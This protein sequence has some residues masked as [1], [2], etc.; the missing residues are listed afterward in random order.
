MAILHLTTVIA[1]IAL[2][3]SSIVKSPSNDGTF[4][5]LILHNNDMHARFE[6]TS[7]LSGA[8][9]TADRDAGKCYG[10]FPRVAHV[11]KEA[12]KAAESGE[13]PPVLYLNAGDTYTGT[14]WFTI[15]KWKIAAEF[16]NALQPD[17]VSLGNNEF[18]TDKI[19][20]SP[21]MQSL[22][23]VVIATNVIVNTPEANEKIKKS[24]VLNINNVLVGIVGYLT[25][26]SSILDSAGN[27]EYIDEVLALT[28]EVNNLKKLNVDIII[29]LGQSSQKDLDV[30][31]EVQGV[32]IVIAGNQNIFY[33]NGTTLKSGKDDPQNIVIITQKSGKRVPVIKAYDYSKYLGKIATKFD[34]NGELINYDANYI[35]LDNSIPQDLEAERMVET[36]RTNLKSSSEIVG[37]TAVVLDAS[38]CKKEECNFGNLV[39]D[40][41]ILHYSVNYQ[42]DW[43]WTDAAIAIIHGGA[44][45]GKIAP[46]QRPGD[47][48]RNDLLSALPATNNLVV[49]N[50]TGKIIKEALEHS[51][52]SYTTSGSD[53]FLQLSGIRV[54]YN[55]DNEPGSRVVNVLVRCCRCTVPDF[56]AIQDTREHKI[57]MPSSLANGEF[58]YSMFKNLPKINLNYDE[59]HCVS[60]FLKLRNPVY[61]EIADRSLGNHEFDNG[62]NGLAPF[63][64]NLSCPNLATNLILDDEPIL[65]AEVNLKNSVVFDINGVKVAVIGYLT[66]DTKFLAIRN[67]VTYIDEVIAIK[68]EVKRL[69]KEGVNIFIALGHSGFVKDLEIAKEI[70]DIDLVIGG[71]TNTFLWNGPT[72]DIEKAQGPYPMIVKQESGR[73]V[74]VVQAYAYTKYIGY[75]HLTFDMQGEIKSIGET[76][77]ILLN[78]SIPEDLELLAIVNKYRD[79]ILKLTDVIVGSTSV[80]LDGQSCRLRECNLG[81]MI[82]DAIVQ[83]Y[84]SEYTGPGWTD[85]PIAITQGGGIRAS[86]SHVNKISDITWGDLLTVMPF[87]D[88]VVKVT[89]HGSDVRIM[90][91]HSVAAYNTIR[92]PGQFLQISGMQIEYDFSR[93]PGNRVSEALILCGECE[94]PLYLPLNDTRPYNILINGF[95][96]MGGDGY[97]IFIG[98]PISLGNHEFDQGVSGLTP[99]IENLKSPVLAANLILTKVP[100]LEKEVNLRNSI[101][102]NISGT[103]IGVI[104]YLTPETKHLVLPN[105]VE[106]IEEVTALQR[107]VKNLKE[108]GVKII[109]A[110]GH[111]GYL[112]DLEI[113]KKVDGL[114]LVIGGHTNT[115]LWN[116]TSPDTEKIIGPYPTYVTQTSGKQVPVVQ[117]YAYTKYLG[118]LHMVFN[119]EGELLR[120]DGNPI[121]LDNS[122]P[123]D[124]EVL[125]IINQYKEKVLNY[126]EEV[127]G[128]TSV[129]L[130]GLSCQHTECNLGN[131]IADAM[132]Y[133]YAMEY[134]GEHWTDAPIAVIQGG[135]IRSSISVTKIPTTITK[136]DL[137]AVLPFEGIL[138][139]VRMTGTILKKM[140]EHAISLGNHE[141]DEAVAGLVPF[142]KNLTSPVL[143][144][145][146]LLDNVPELKEETNLY[147]SIIL[148]KKGVNIGIVGYLTPETKFLAPKTKVDYEDEIT[149]VRREVKKLKQNGIDIII[150]L[151]HSGFIKDLEIATEVEDIDLVIGGHSNTFLSN[152]NTTE[153]PEFVQGPYPTIV[154]QKS[155]RKVLVVQAYAYT[156]YMGSL[157]LK[158]NEKG[159]IMDFD[160]KPILL[161]E[162]IPQ[163][164][165]VLQIVEKYHTD[166]DRINNEIVGAS[167]TFLQ[168]DTCRLFECNLG[169]FICDTMLNYTKRHYMEFSQVNIALI[170]GGRIRTSLDQPKKPY[171]LTRGD[172]IT[173]IP[174]SDTLC[175]VK[176]NGSVLMQAL[177][178]SVDLWR[179]IDTPG[180]FL[181]MSGMEV[182]YDLEKIPGHRVVSAKAMCIG[183][184]KLI[185]VRNDLKYNILMSAFL[186]DGGDGY[187]MFENLEKEFVSFNEVTC[188]L[189]YLGIYSPINPRVDKRITILNED[190]V[191]DFVNDVSIID[192]F[193]PSS[194]KAIYLDS[195]SIFML[196]VGVTIFLF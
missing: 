125:N 112:K 53:R 132:V 145:N 71:H 162:E 119:S 5:L 72:P 48:T 122:I 167:M 165:V 175:I 176:M 140:L 62:I 54:T 10:G 133:R 40:S 94:I 3:S 67:N 189:D 116:G 77:P 90:L 76:N 25:P 159:D 42:A 169:D 188:V 127:I 46:A 9:T 28:E 128:N 194:G 117:A 100:E 160:G 64:A 172:W 69:Q 70:E 99:F 146:L 104:G 34:R 29:A 68:A 88:K 184:S 186:A 91:E 52:S 81:N 126:T 178:H 65:K 63:I 102:F 21:L 15:Y 84:A 108:D 4:E 86:I 13:G 161:N 32:D 179:K 129:V 109:I 152:V 56:Y 157:F 16:L 155:G 177:E 7:Q 182:T 55:F 35:V 123:Q 114:S 154:M 115:F 187:S 134:N 120:A 39:T 131:L 95:L 24:V 111:S 149:S 80:F 45:N 47:I 43:R 20:L 101:V 17:A 6:Q 185:D 79:S 139:L 118:K 141:F 151:G 138:V 2:S 106:Y 49:V 44:L 124:P 136:G 89:L 105:D 192:K 59:V 196:F 11:V 163:D 85:T 38:S 148:N 195:L 153:I 74:P 58:G 92:A 73:K 97:S 51:V 110:L 18:D 130:D 23:T 150:A 87:D 103:P 82:T 19:S 96:S 83:K 156:K 61:P 158:F 147:K 193:S 60:E 27:I 143:A 181:Q 190:K 8:C 170:Q 183:C 137:I 142:I 1:V 93:S 164:P 113:A 37:K 14:A 180:Q 173:V 57:I 30:A 75:M 191:Q 174:F 41:V 121:L 26:S 168:G 31:R 33:T 66:P 36:L 12:R 166:I 22:N 107:E 135:G 144:A 50:V 78:S 171:N 98:K